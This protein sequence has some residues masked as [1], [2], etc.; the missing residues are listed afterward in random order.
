MRN[1]ARLIAAVF[2]ILTWKEAIYWTENSEPKVEVRKKE[3]DSK[4]D[5]LKFREDFHCAIPALAKRHDFY[6]GKCGEFRL[7]E[8]HE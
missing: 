4:E 7:E 1:H 8:I 2:Y 6:F 5:A 3:F